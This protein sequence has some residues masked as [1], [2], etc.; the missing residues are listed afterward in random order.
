MDDDGD[1]GKP[2]R[3]GDRLERMA[4]SGFPAQASHCFGV[5]PPNRTPRPAATTRTKTRPPKP[6]LLITAG[7]P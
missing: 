7:G 1:S 3:A 4:N 6:R 5:A 2:G